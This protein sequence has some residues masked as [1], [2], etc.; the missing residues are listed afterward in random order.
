[1]TRLFVSDVHLDASA[2]EAVAQ[3]LQFLQTHAAHAQALY[4][5]GDLFETWVGDDDLDPAK[6]RV[7]EG[8]RALTARG[9]GCFVLHGN[10]DFLLGSDFCR[11]TGC[12]LLTDPVVADLDG[13]RVLL[14]H[15][16]ALCTDDHSYQELR[17]IVR[18]PQWQRRF[19]A[20]PLADRELLANQARAG[21]RQHASRTVPDIMDVNAG[22][23]AAAFRAT[24][25]RRIVH[26]HTHRPGVHDLAIE[27]MPAQRIVLGAWYEQGSYLVHENGRYELRELPRCTPPAGGN[28][29]AAG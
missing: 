5:L 23:V 8:L 6:A 10:R 26:G 19:L 21:S 20:L 12:R 3:F 7:C 13:D 4:I 9:V 11:S 2:P 17:S 28:S 22:T 14:T 1:M 29:I 18:A 16:D 24:G 25:V 15:G 27:G